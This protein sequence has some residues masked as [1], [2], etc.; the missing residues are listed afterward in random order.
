MSVS[1]HKSINQSTNQSINLSVCLSTLH[2]YSFYPFS[3]HVDYMMSASSPNHVLYLSISFCLSVCLSVCYT[4]YPAPPRPIQPLTPCQ[5]LTLSPSLPPFQHLS[6]HPPSI[7][8]AL[9]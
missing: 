9:T 7:S 6:P 5:Y 8:H 4:P 2:F 3:P 1:I